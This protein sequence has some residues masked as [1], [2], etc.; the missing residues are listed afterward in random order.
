MREADDLFKRGFSHARR[1]G[2]YPEMK[3]A[4]RAWG[5]LCADEERHEEAEQ[6]YRIAL[7]GE[8]QIGNR[9]GMVFA[10]QRIGNSLIC[11]GRRSDAEEIIESALALETEVVNEQMRKRG[12]NPNEHHVSSWSL[13][14]LLFCREQYEEARRLYKEKVAFWEK[15]GARPDQIDLGHLQ[16]RLAVSA[17]R[18]GHLAEALDLYTRAEKTFERE[19]G[20]G[21]PKAASARDAK[22]ALTRHMAE[23]AR[24]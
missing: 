16:M 7:Q 24:S 2:C 23:S 5:D 3:P 22:A 17:T 9:A 1:S 13:P 21:H 20:E 11:Q 6:R 12:K 14:D 4:Y 15:S 18:T 19:W 10:L 8:E